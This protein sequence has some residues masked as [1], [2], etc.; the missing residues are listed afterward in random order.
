MADKTLI[1][2]GAWVD[3]ADTIWDP[4]FTPDGTDALIM[5]T[6]DNVTLD[7]SPG[8]G[9]SLDMTGYTGTLTMGTNNLDIGGNVILQGAFVASVGSEIACGGD[10]TIIAGTAFGSTTA[11]VMDNPGGSPVIT[12][13]GVN[14]GPLEIAAGPI[15][16]YLLADALTCTTFTLTTGIFSLNY[17]MTVGN[18]DINGGT[19]NLDANST[20]VTSGTFTLNAGTINTRGN[21]LTIEDPTVVWGDAGGS[22]TELILELTGTGTI[23]WDAS[24]DYI[25]ELT[26]I[27]TIETSA[28]VYVRVLSG[29]GDFTVSH[30]VVIVPTAANWWGVSGTTDGGGVIQAATSNSPGGDIDVD[31]D[32]KWTSG[33]AR[34]PTIDGDFTAN[35]VQI[36]KTGDAGVYAIT[37][38]DGKHFTCD[39]LQIGSDV[40][41][42]ESSGSVAFGANTTNLIDGAI[43]AGKATNTANAITFKG[44]T[45]ITDAWSTDDITTISS[46]GTI[47][48]TGGIT[49]DSTATNDTTWTLDDTTIDGNFRVQETAGTTTLTTAAAAAKT[50]TVTGSLILAD[51]PV[52]TPS[53]LDVVM[54]GFLKT[55]SWADFGS[56]FK[57][58]TISSIGAIGRTGGVITNALYI[59]GEVTGN[60]LITLTPTANDYLEITGEISGNT[61]EIN[62]ASDWSNS[63]AINAGSE[64]LIY[65]AAA[66]DVTFTQTGPITHTGNIAIVASEATKTATLDIQ[67]GSWLG[68]IVL[69]RAA[70]LDKSGGLVLDGKVYS[71][72]S[73]GAGHDDNTGNFVTLTGSTVILSGIFNGNNQGTTMTITSTGAN[74]HGGTLTDVTCTGVLY[75]WGVTE[76]NPGNNSNT[77]ANESS[78]GGTTANVGAGMMGIAA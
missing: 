38:A 67:V 25:N 32:W 41:G 73:L 59:A 55:I 18:V 49:L 76:G 44:E 19:F 69:G 58:L 3:N 48:A 13:N 57:S 78:L 60:N 42:N 71:L 27:G 7:V 23:D 65:L 6:A 30:L 54:T 39:S 4:G 10:L 70:G 14:L 72:K 64:A 43:T 45:T 21:T 15:A 68:D 56:R 47:I 46:A 35:D 16:S 5:A 36:A 63:K 24:E 40:A 52:V 37:M 22:V 75:A 12:T 9:A 29:A 51:T 28:T 1:G 11:I 61:I 33:S 74:L 77:I 50:L 66:G 26:I 53:V 20:I 2:T 8:L 17:Q 31:V 62:T 34:T